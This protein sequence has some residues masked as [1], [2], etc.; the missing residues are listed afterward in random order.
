MQAILKYFSLRFYSKLP[1]VTYLQHEENV[2]ITQGRTLEGKEKIIERTR[3]TNKY[4]YI[5]Q[6]RI[7]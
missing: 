6:Y 7:P 3:Y 2:L 4:N 5:S 1:S